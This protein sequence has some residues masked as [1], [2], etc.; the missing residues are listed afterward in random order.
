MG[1]TCHSVSQAIRHGAIGEWSSAVT[2]TL[3]F[4]FA[5]RFG[6]HLLEPFGDQ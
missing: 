6:D 1:I 4:I 2:K 5:S 3:Q